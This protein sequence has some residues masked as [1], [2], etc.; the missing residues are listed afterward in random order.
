MLIF[1]DID[2]VM[3]PAASWKKTEQLED[4]FATFSI[5]SV[6][7]LNSLIRPDTSIILTTSHRFRYSHDEWISIFQR[8]GIE[9]KKLY[10]LNNGSNRKEEI[11]NWFNTNTISTDFI[12]IDDDKSLNDLP[13][14]LK[15]HLILT[16]PLVGLTK[17]DL[18]K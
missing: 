9:L 6:Q 1:L 15:N 10:C 5:A 13:M 8:R 2:G 18:L 7:A 14:N 16:T 12:I 11:V 4:G 17:K 3:V